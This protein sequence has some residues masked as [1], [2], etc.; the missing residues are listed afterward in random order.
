M[1]KYGLKLIILCLLFTIA[2]SFVTLIYIVRYYQRFLIATLIIN[3]VISLLN[4]VFLIMEIK[5]KN[6][7]REDI[8]DNLS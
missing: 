2:L 7:K 1:E 5:S 8:N 6:K 4:V 3:I